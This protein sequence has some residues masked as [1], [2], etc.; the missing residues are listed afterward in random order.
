MRLLLPRTRGQRSRVVRA[1]GSRVANRCH[2]ATTTKLLFFVTEDWYFVSHRLPLALAAKSAG[3]D[4]SVVTRVREMGDTIRAAGLRLIPFENSRS[5]MNPFNELW[6]LA[7]LVQIYRRERPGI[8][9]HVAIKPV[10]Y[11]AIAARLAG[12]PHVVNALAGMGWLSTASAGGVAGWLKIGACWV[13]GRLLQSGMAIVQNPDDVELLVQ[14]GVPESR[15]RIV[16]GS[17][18]DLG[19][20]TPYPEPADVTVLVLPA[21]LLWDKGVGEF[22]AAARLLKREGIA[23]RF[24]LVGTPDKS[25]PSSI[26]PKQIA[27]WV[28]EGVVEYLGWVTDMPR[29]FA[30]CHI[31]CLPSYREGMPKSL[32]EA[33]AAGRPIV[34]TDTPGCREVV[35]HGENGLLVPPRDAVALAGALKQLILNRSLREGMGKRGRE[36]AESEFSIE[37]VAQQTLAI[38]G[39]LLL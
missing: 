20:F 19:R 21:R 9:H 39:E 26:S 31:V 28:K 37:K 6:T 2:A 8:V 36:I 13:L 22:V 38:Y 3:Y 30:N 10:L 17:G 12:G 16:G 15:I 1:D 4:V 14:L 23:A 27:A 33:A 7:R 11:G 25:N 34:T 35:R 32:I 5:G 29:L 18:V 24:M